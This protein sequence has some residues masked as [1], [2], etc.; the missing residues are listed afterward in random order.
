MRKQAFEKN[1]CVTYS[2]DHLSLPTV[3]KKIQSKLNLLYK[4]V[5]E[6]LGYFKS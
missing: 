2:K 3:S 4:F 1:A 5:L 6:T